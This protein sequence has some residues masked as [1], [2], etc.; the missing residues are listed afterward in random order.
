M[1]RIYYIAINRISSIW[2]A[3]FYNKEP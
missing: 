2:C 1:S 3:C